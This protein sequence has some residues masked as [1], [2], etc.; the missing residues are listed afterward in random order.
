MRRAQVGPSADLGAGAVLA[1]HASVGANV[2]G[3]GGEPPEYLL[4]SPYASIGDSG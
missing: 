4:I 3:F 2:V 1:V